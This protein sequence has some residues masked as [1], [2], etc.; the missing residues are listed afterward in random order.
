MITKR[1]YKESVLYKT[2]RKAQLYQFNKKKN[3]MCKYYECM[4]EIA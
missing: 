2:T 1:I 3:K 4:K